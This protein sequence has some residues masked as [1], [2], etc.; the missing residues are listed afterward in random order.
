MP[1]EKDDNLKSL[2]TVVST[3]GTAAGTGIPINYL[4][5]IGIDRYDCSFVKNFEN[6][7]CEKDCRDLAAVLTTKYEQFELYREDDTA[8]PILLND[9]AGKQ[10]ILSRIQHF[11]KNQTANQLNNNLII[12]FSGHG[13]SVKQGLTEM[14]CWIPYG[15]KEFSYDE[16]LAYD[17]F[18]PLL[19]Q[20]CTENFLLISD[21]CRSGQIFNEIKKQNDIANAAKI[22]G[23]ELSSWAIVSSRSNED[24][25]SGGPNRGSCFTEKLVEAL[26]KFNERKFLI[27]DL[28]AR[29][30][31]A[32]VNDEEQ[33]SY[34]GRLSL[35]TLPN[36]GQ[37]ILHTKQEVLNIQKRREFLQ[38]NLAELNYDKQKARFID[39]AAKNANLFAIFTGTQNCGL[40]HVSHQAKISVSFPGYKQNALRINPT[41]D[42]GD[43]NQRILQVFN[44]AFSKFNKSFTALD[45]L[46][47]YILS[48]L[49]KTHIVLELI[50]Y[51][52]DG[53]QES[54]RE[55][56]KKEF[57]DQV[58][59]F[60]SAINKVNAD[61]K[62]LFI[63]V[64]DE[65]DCDYEKLYGGKNIFDIDTVY[66]PKIECMDSIK[67]KE[68]YDRMR[69]S[70]AARG[71][72]DLDEFD[73]LFENILLEK[74]DDLISSTKGFP[75]SMLSSICRQAECEELAI[76]ILDPQ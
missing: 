3:P 67:A 4:I 42:A 65:Q 9:N 22:D 68:W 11:V 1:E 47:N 71:K 57:M 2:G 32:F 23:H 61:D 70:V 59:Q 21:S 24:S 60:V 8:E 39:L 41:L 28:A 74:I 6:K 34:W 31:A 25:K 72:S 36:S 15:C 18:I 73:A 37:F 44:A 58:A 17:H 38:L 10:K 55:K 30:D 66:M 35:S 12:Y 14:G 48:V 33:K 53:I 5:A 27:S 45:A 26:T 51:T 49:Q 16:V 64:V 43:W 54:W 13:G 62:G 29:L 7:N 46:H 50:F 20:V 40:R 52:D 63:F 69:R 75:G 76:Q 19:K 56:D